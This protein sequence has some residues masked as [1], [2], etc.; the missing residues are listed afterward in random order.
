MLAENVETWTD[1]WKREG[2]Q[3]GLQEALE[4]G[5]EQGREQGLEQGRQQ[6]GREATRHLLIRQVRR[7]FG[8]TIATQTEPLLA[9]INDLQQLEDLGDQLLISPDGEDW[10]RAV[11]AIQPA[12]ER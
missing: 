1:Q 4:Q 8:P 6:G 3:Q 12:S 7:R 11:R 9:R 5:R 10:L 2:L